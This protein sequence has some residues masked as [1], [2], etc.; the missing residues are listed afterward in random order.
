MRVSATGNGADDRL[1]FVREYNRLARNVCTPPRKPPQEARRV[2]LQANLAACGTALEPGRLRTHGTSEIHKLRHCSP[3]VQIS[4]LPGSH[5]PPVHVSPQEMDHS[6]HPERLRPCAESQRREARQ[7]PTQTQPQRHDRPKL[8]ARE[9][10]EG[11]RAGGDHP[12]LRQELV[13]SAARARAVVLGRT[14]VCASHCPLS[15]P[16]W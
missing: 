8:A 14:Y 11:C 7:D 2:R 1:E 16:E 4:N 3:G 5:D 10:A 9:G 12:H 13:A 15:G 6:H